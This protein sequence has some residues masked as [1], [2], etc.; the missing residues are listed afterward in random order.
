MNALTTGKHVPYRDSVLT[1]LL[2]DSLGGNCKTTLLIA[3][4]C[5]SF[6]A[7][8]TISAKVNR[9]KA[10]AEYKKVIFVYHFSSFVFVFV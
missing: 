10:A 1:R 2:S 8:E 9:E 4:S 3:A 6:S 7:E 5:S